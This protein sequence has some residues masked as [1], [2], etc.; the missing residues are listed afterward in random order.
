[1]LAEVP[2]VQED[3]AGARIALLWVEPGDGIGSHS[4][5]CGPGLRGLAVGADDV[6]PVEVD[7]ELSRVKPVCSFLCHAPLALAAPT[8]RIGWWTAELSSTAT[9]R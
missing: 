2:R 3:R 4:G 5:G 8:S 7:G 6:A 9:E 1:M